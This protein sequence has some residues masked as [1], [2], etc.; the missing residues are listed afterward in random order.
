MHTNRKNTAILFFTMVVVMLGFGIVI[1][2]LPFYVE[3]FGAGGTELGFLMATFAIMQFFFSP[4]WGD[5]SDRYGRKPFLMIGTLGNGLAMLLFGLSTE[6]WML[7]TA[8]ALAGILSAATLP[9]AMAYISDS[10]SHADRGRGMGIIGAAMGVGMVIGPGLGGSLAGISLS[11]PF[12]LSAGVL[13]AAAALILFALPESLPQE[14]RLTTGGKKIRGPQ[15]KAMWQALFSPIGILLILAFTLSFGLTNFEGIFGLYALERFDYG[16]QEVGLLLAG[17]GITSAVVQGMLT[18]P[19]TKRW[20]DVA[21]IRAAL[22]GSAIGFGA[23]LL[24]FNFITVLLTV[25]FFVLSTALLRPSVS[26]LTSKRAAGGQGMAMG[27]NNSFM[28][29]GR[30]VGPIWAGLIFDVNIIL[31]YLSG[32][33][34]MLISFTISMIWLKKEERAA[35]SRDGWICLSGWKILFLMKSRP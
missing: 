26:S 6:L 20:G 1:P 18:G 9:T 11:A 35:S 27:L 25:M 2:I 14:K 22:F 23:M 30:I 4:V 5:L 34:I 29:L 7:F 10:T 3:S 12:F 19:L 16:P 31:P 28:S 15:L 21:V 13:V 8:R 33:I 17:I 24:A 32:A